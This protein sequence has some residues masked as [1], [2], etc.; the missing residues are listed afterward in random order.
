MRTIRTIT[1][2]AINAMQP[3]QTIRDPMLKGFGVRYRNATISYFVHTEVNRRQRWYT[4]GT[5][6]SPWT[7]D[8]A[9]KRAK[10]ILYETEHGREPFKDLTLADTTTFKEMFDRFA[11]H[12]GPHIKPS[13]LKEYKRLAAR[14]IVPHFKGTPF[15]AITRADCLALQRKLVLTPSAANHTTSIIR[16]VFN[17]AAKEELIPE[18]LNPC[19]KIRKFKERSRAQFL[20]V[21]DLEQLALSMREALSRG[22]ATPIQVSTILLLL[23]TGARRSEIFTLKRS[24]VDQHR[25]IAHLPDSK[26]GAK[27]LHLG[28]HAMAVLDTIPE[29]AG[30][31]YYL[32]GRFPGSCITEIKKP[33]DKI[34]KRAGLETFRLHDFR[35]S[36][37]SFA[38][39]TGASAR[40]IGALLG[41]ASIETTKIYMH[42]FNN[43]A[44][45]TASSAGHTI[46]AIMTGASPPRLSSPVCVPQATHSD[47][48]DHKEQD[49]FFPPH[50][51]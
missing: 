7:P 14:T 17:W 35:H 11:E 45:E 26:T 16:L 33:W 43:R 49:I 50:C 22:E 3:G 13:T 40:A 24:Y 18:A 23:F 6:G 37:A 20:T 19:R 1:I 34:R 39:D 44:K 2:A 46:S 29:V 48:Q 5:H 32:A 9:R 38:A 41:H 15:S 4:I 12:H 10:E 28:P 42:L 31:P 36:F 21:E 30:N 51:G 27:V 47:P 25:M 8:S